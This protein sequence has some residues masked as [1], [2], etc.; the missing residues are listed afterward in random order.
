M[1]ISHAFITRYLSS[2]TLLLYL[3]QQ[4]LVARHFKGAN[5]DRHT[6]LLRVF[7]SYSHFAYVQWF[8]F[9][10]LKCIDLDHLLHIDITPGKHALALSTQTIVNT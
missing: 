3:C 4:Q 10:I 1:S 9:L 6:L 7:H 8:T 5:L 2:A